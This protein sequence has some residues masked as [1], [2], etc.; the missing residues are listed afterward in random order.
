[1]SAGFH[2]L[3]PTNI[4]NRVFSTGSVGKEALRVVLAPSDVT[5]SVATVVEVSNFPVSQTVDGTVNIGNLPI[6]FVTAQGSVVTASVTGTVGVNNFPTTIQTVQGSVVTASINGTVGINNFP[7][8]TQVSNFPTTQS[9]EVL[10]LGRRV[11][12]LNPLSVDLPRGQHDSF[13]RLRVSENVTLFDSQFSYDT[14]P[15]LWQTTGSLGSQATHRSDLAAV[16]MSVP[17]T[18][19]ASVIRQTY[20]YFRY[21]PGKSQYIL[22]TGIMG[23]AAVGSI[24]R[25]GYFDSRNG[26]FFQAS[27]SGVQVV[28]RSSLTTQDGLGQGVDAVVPQSLW[29]LDKM[30][31]NG[32]SGIALDIT[33]AQIFMVDFQWLGTGIV[34]FGF[35]GNNGPVYVH[36]VLNTNANPHVYMTSPNLP[37]RYEIQNIEGGVGSSMEQ[38]CSSVISEGGVE[39]ARG[40]L[41]SVSNK[42]TPVIVTNVG[43]IPVL[44]IRPKARIMTTVQTIQGMGYRNRI[45][46]IPE[47]CDLYVTTADS[48]F[49]NI[50]YGGTLTNATWIA[51]VNSGSV[52]AAVEADVAASAITGGLTVDG[53]YSSAVTGRVVHLDLHSR[54]P[55]GLDINGQNPNVYTI[56]AQNMAAGNANVVARFQWKELY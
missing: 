24:K 53:G 3:D 38:I 11:Q 26:V 52:E 41:R 29:N 39:E 9:I 44:S 22:M 45:R 18:A 21:Q 20:E 50:I 6:T 13:G 46:I 1:M 16:S 55:F 27:G 35:G 49:F 23:N 56:V 5:G 42:T 34:R 54:L 7:A 47:S 31:G 2:L 32:A 36:Q 30:D 28:L 10:Q 15:L 14:L 37:L 48:I 17:A 12:D 4:F 40:I 8:S 25:I 33:K 43:L 51:Q 19:N